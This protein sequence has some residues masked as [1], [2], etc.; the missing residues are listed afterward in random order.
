MDLVLTAVTGCSW[1]TDV[2]R[3]AD[4]PRCARLLAGEF[5]VWV[6]VE[7]VARDAGCGAIRGAA[8][9]R[10][11][12]V[13][14][15]AARDADPEPDSLSGQVHASGVRACRRVPT[16]QGCWAPSRTACAAAEAGATFVLRRADRE[17][18][19]MHTGSFTL[20]AAAREPFRSPTSAL[21]RS[22]VPSWPGIRGDG[23]R[24]ALRGRRARK[25]SLL[26]RVLRTCP[27][28]VAAATWRHRRLDV[29]GDFYDVYP[30][31]GGWGLA[32][33]DVAGK[34]REAPPYRRGPLRDPGHRD[35]WGPDCGVW[36]LIP[37][38]FVDK[39]SLTLSMRAD[40]ATTRPPHAL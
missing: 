13:D 30:I 25:A 16:T 10:R 24:Q 17:P 37:F 18:S 14:R 23:C 27:D 20:S 40:I 29:G 39:H 8:R 1:R 19:I 28:R 4:P 15:A 34:A 35:H 6:V 32:I 22:G 21:A 26:P 31:P 2:Q 5:G 36:T 33:G 9:R 7:V 12:G 38:F 11:P 3:I